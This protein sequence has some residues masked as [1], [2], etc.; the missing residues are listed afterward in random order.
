MVTAAEE[1]APISNSNGNGNGNGNVRG[2]SNGDSQRG[3]ADRVEDFRSPDSKALRSHA[4]WPSSEA[5]SAAVATTAG[6]CGASSATPIAP[7]SRTLERGIF[8]AGKLKVGG[9]IFCL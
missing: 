1:S 5:M 3:I 8:I 6:A 7:N 4:S 2:T 9:P